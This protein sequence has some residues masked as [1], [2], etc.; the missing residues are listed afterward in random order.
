M[1]TVTVRNHEAEC[2]TVYR[3]ID[4]IEDKP[5]VFKLY[6]GGFEKEF[7]KDIYSIQRKDG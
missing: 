1:M 3:N 7:D 4:R 2:D 5:S 6:M